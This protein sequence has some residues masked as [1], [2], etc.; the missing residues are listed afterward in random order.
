MRT[1][2]HKTVVDFKPVRLAQKLLGHQSSA[3]QF[4]G[5]TPGISIHLRK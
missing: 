2:R 1:T 5:L 4:A 3:G